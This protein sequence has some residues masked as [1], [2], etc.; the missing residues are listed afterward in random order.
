MGF[1]SK[2]FSLEVRIEIT[3]RYA[4][5]IRMETETFLEM[6]SK[7]FGNINLVCF[8]MIRASI[9]T[10]AF[11]YFTSVLF[12]FLRKQKQFGLSDENKSKFDYLFQKS[13]SFRNDKSHN[14]FLLLTMAT[15]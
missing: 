10:I 3:F 6:F 4:V 7:L 2:F 1:V 9:E 15:K 5:L 11:H 8:A 14:L 13:F 12:C